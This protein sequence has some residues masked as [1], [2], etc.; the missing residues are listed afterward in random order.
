MCSYMNRD[1]FRDQRQQKRAADSASGPA[2]KNY[3]GA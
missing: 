3:H 2:A 1:T